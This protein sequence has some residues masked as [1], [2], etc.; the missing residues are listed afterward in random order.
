MS[1]K[2]RISSGVSH[3][4]RLLGGLFVGDNVVWYDDSGSLAAVFCLNF[5]QASLSQ[6][7]PV[8]YVSFDR[9]PKNL[10]EKLGPMAESPYL[11]ILDGFTCGKGEGI[12]TFM[13][14]YEEPDPERLCHLKIID[15]PQD[16]GYVTNLLYEHLDTMDGDVRL[17]FESMTGM[18]KI[19]GGEEAI[20][21]FYS[22]SCPRL[23]ELNTIAYWVM[24]KLAHSPRLRAQINQIAQVAINLCISRGTTTLT[25]IKAEDRG[26][27]GIHEPYRYW[28][29]DLTVMFDTEKQGPRQLNLGLRIKELRVK[30]GLS[31]TELGKLVGVNPSTISQVEA[32]I[33]YPSLPAL[34][35]IA[36]VLS[37]N[38][39]SL[40]QQ[41]L[42]LE[43][44]IIF[45]AAEA[46]DIGFKDVPGRAIRG[47][48][49]T[50]P[51][52]DG[53]MEPYIIEI[54]PNEELPVH[55]FIHK[56]EEMGYVLSGKLQMTL[57]MASYTVR[58]GDVIYL[59][60]DMPSQW[61]NPGPNVTRLLWIKAK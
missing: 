31:Q 54:E 3:L 33:I 51:D 25:I 7:K 4:D 53:K 58:A 55:F 35:K 6:D 22:H 61:K 8:I 27:E 47:R 37:V 60:T 46:V 2:I 32:N 45:P 49:L 28:T 42:D 23:Y 5:L 56:G 20:L 13:K 57:N 16:V 59:T 10:L 24:E 15:R 21:T 43:K 36:E 30:R 48:L 18:H 44:R 11:T 40:F 17:I 38:V 12:P 14:F 39:A 9:S 52:F 26:T 1:E 34:L 50:P 19:W 41:A 29:K